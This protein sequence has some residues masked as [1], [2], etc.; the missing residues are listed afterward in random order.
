MATCS[1]RQVVAVTNTGKK[2]KRSSEERSFINESAPNF[3]VDSDEEREA[4]KRL[5]RAS[6]VSYQKWTSS[7]GS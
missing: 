7:E 3:F 5:I 2:R 1:S 6:K 4:V